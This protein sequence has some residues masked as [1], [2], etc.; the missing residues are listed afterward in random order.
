M[1]IKRVKIEKECEVNVMFTVSLLGKF[2]IINQND[3]L[4][5]RDIRSEMV[6]KLLSYIII[7]REHILTVQELSNALWQEDE[8]DNPGGALKNLMYRLRSILK[9]AFGEESFIITSRGAY[10]WN[11]DIKLFVDAEFFDQCCENAKRSEYT[12]EDKLK[13]YEDAISWYQGDLLSKYSDMHWVIP[14]ATYYHSLFLSSTKNLAE[15]YLETMRHP[16]LEKLC[17]KALKFD[18]VDEQLHYYMIK[19]LIVQNK[20]ELAKEYYEQA[21]KILFSTLGVESSVKLKEVQRELLK[22]KKS[23]SADEMDIVY[24][25]MLEEE[26]EGAYV[27]GYSVFRE[28]YRLEARRNKRFGLA[29]YVLLITA[30]ISEQNKSKEHEQVDAFHIKRTMEHLEIVLKDSL[31]IGDV[32][33]RYSD[34]QYVVLLPTC[35]YESSQMIANRILVKLYGIINF[36]R[37][38]M[39]M[40]IEEVTMVE[41]FANR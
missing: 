34:T 33:S 23:S 14:I 38:C 16:E 1:T 41:P 37:V 30:S 12:T 26:P 8:T 18:N 32:A 21:E 11:P 3:V 13:Y 27:C 10:T 2:Q 6:V 19:S 7:H 29:E 5:E 36:K 39:K 17:A 31:R 4:T 9:K 22:M 24:R 25:D 15:L 40:D 28:I 35:T 20:Y